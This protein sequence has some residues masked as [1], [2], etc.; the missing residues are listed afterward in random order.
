MTT[1]LV[2]MAVVSMMLGATI[3]VNALAPGHWT[4]G[5]GG[6]L[7]TIRPKRAESA[8]SYVA[9]RIRTAPGG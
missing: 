2:V 4:W 5:I 7:G 1:V 9:R 8:M 3:V 6:S